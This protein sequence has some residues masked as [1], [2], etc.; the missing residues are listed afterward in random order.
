[1]FL[2]SYIEQKPEPGQKIHFFAKVS[3]T[4][5]RENYFGN[6]MERLQNCKVNLRTNYKLQDSFET[7]KKIQKLF[8]KSPYSS[9]R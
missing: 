2:I 3:T 1:M 5:L 6:Y 7:V 9:L 4:S 8:F